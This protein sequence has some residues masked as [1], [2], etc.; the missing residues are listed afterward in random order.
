MLFAK[1]GSDMEMEM[2]YERRLQDTRD[3][4]NDG[5]DSTSSLEIAGFN[6]LGGS[7]YDHLRHKYGV[8]TITMAAAFRCAP[9][10]WVVMPQL[11][12]LT[13]ILQLSCL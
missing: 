11:P 2:E 5:G 7:F 13:H 9:T 1:I 6:P 10:S 12:Q 3:E 8:G 4:Q